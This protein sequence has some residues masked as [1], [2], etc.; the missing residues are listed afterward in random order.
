M[1]FPW[2]G[3]KQ[4]HS[5]VGNGRGIHRVST[6]TRTDSWVGWT[7]ISGNLQLVY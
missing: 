5:H 6:A 1:G 7:A 2:V 3:E 4:A